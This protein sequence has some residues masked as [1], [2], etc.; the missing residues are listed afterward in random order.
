MIETTMASFFGRLSY[1]YA[2]K[3]LLEGSIRRDGAS[4]FPTNNKYALFPAVSAG[5]VVSKE[6]F[7]NAAIVN[8]LKVR[9]SWGANGSKSNLPGNED[10]E[11][12]VFSQYGFPIRYPDATDTYQSGAR[13]EKLINP[14][15]VWERTE[16]T[17]IGVDLGFFNNRLTF[18][19]D[20]YNKLTKDLITVGTG[21]LSVGNNYP[22]VNAGDVSNKG[23]DFELGYRNYSHE[24]KYGVSVNLSTNK[25]EVTSLKVD[26]PVRGDN[27][28]GYDLTWFEEGYPI[29]YFKG[30]KT[31]GIDKTTGEPIVVDVSGD[32]KITPDDQTYIGDPHPDMVFG[33]NIYLEYK[34]F[35]F[36]VFFQGTSGNDIF[37]GWFRTDRPIQ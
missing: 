27:L 26:A 24:L 10:K 32:G 1:N 34:A 18:S 20:Y 14:D 13:I 30:Y 21:P 37:M 3:Y 12:W 36:K 17:D 22:N 19:A 35:D 2:E 11:F 6:D 5:W 33:G 7:F 28:R 4:V 23:F 8:N 31:N 16:M 15:L 29:W 25:N 9:A